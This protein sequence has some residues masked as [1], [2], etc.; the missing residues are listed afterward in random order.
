MLE[1]ELTPAVPGHAAAAYE[2]P[3]DL[4]RFV[5][6]RWGDPPGPDGDVDRLP[7]A[8]TLEGFYAVCYQA[9]MM[10][11]E[12][13]P[14]VFRAIL[15]EPRLFDPE[16]RPPEGLQRLEFPRP[17]PFEPRELR[18][19]SVAADPQRSLIG[20]RQ[21]G[22]GR[23]RIWGLVNSGTRWLRDVQGGRR[24][25]APLPPAPVVRVDAP[26]SMEA[27]KGH[28]LVGKLQG[29]KLSGL[30]L[31]PFESEWLPGQFTGL[32][33]ELLG[34]HEAARSSARELAGERWAAL[35]PTLAHR[36]TRR[37]MQRVVSVLREA[38]HGGTVIFV[39]SEN[40]AQVPGG[41]PPYIDLRFPFADNP[42][43]STFPD[44]VVDI[45]NRLAKI[46]GAAD[47]EREPGTVGW[48]EFERT[49]D[50]GIATL[51]EAL[52][53]TAHLIAGLAAADGA[54]VMG[55]DNELLGFG[56]MISGRL[57][58]VETVCRA[59]DLEGEEVAEEETGDVGA[60]HRSAYRLVGAL[61]GSLAIVVSQDGGVRWVCQK[62]GRV[63][64]W[65]QE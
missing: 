58:D 28:E 60:R 1:G 37:M 7:D 16:G 61:P 24:A 44:L 45:L 55:K 40:D 59:L 33:E 15:A 50:D 12:E 17:L 18:R 43:R 64:Y 57:R 14:V 29:G 25:G 4:A 52:F 10:R 22:E 21:D 3:G 46:C 11:E 31:D 2:Y 30:R 8:G 6:E 5:R 65:E 63:T 20:V 56:G 47:H 42:A 54:V 9:S 34:R 26:G 27:Y 13:R 35:E 49:T 36:I 39:P 48:E 41:E 19:L 53:E 38:R 23:L 51:D 32:L 62:G